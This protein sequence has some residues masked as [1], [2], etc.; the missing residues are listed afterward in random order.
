MN[1]IKTIGGA[2][3]SLAG[4]WTLADIPIVNPLPAIGLGWVFLL[5]GLSILAP[6]LVDLLLGEDQ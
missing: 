6:A 4:V 1:L 3:L 5:L 2:A